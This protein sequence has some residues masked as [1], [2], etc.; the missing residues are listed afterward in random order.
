MLQ[1]CMSNSKAYYFGIMLTFI[2]V[3]F[4]LQTVKSF[5]EETL[6]AI[7]DWVLDETIAET[8]S[9]SVETFTNSKTLLPPPYTH[10]ESEQMV[11]CA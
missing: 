7:P 10:P 8:P 11:L 4:I 1:P 5:F 9:S 2:I 6:D 3:V